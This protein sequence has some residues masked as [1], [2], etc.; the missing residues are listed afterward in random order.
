MS[1]MLTVLCIQN[2]LS[3]L[4]CDIHFVTKIVNFGSCILLITNGISGNVYLYYSSIS[5]GNC[6]VIFT[7][8]CFFSV[9]LYSANKSILIQM[10]CDSLMFLLLDCAKRNQIFFVNCTKIGSVFVWVWKMSICTY[11]C[12]TV[13]SKVVITYFCYEFQRH[14]TSI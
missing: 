11:F 1:C 13:W 12:I 10:I 4:C 7:I 14:T 2:K 3:M 9:F 6:H 8:S 5:Y